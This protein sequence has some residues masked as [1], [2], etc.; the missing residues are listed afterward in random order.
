MYK[1]QWVDSLH[2]EG[3]A[4]RTI[5]YLSPEYFDC[6]AAQPELGRYFALGKEVLVCLGGVAYRVTAEPPAR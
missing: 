2:T 4:V 3:M 1:R 5:A 6:L